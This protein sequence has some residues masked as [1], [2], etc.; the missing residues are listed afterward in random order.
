MQ[1]KI[2]KFGRIVIPKPAR[3]ALALEAGDE[4]EVEIREQETGGRTISLLP[5]KQQL[6]FKRK[7][8]VLVFTGKLADSDYDVVEHVRKARE[9]RSRRLSGRE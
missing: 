4:L 7:G 3:D 5:I 6:P 2:D 8:D 1:T 9:E